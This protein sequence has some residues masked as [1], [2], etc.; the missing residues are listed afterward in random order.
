[1][2]LRKKSLSITISE[3][4]AEAHRLL[5]EGKPDEHMAYVGDAVAKYPRD[6]DLRHQYAISL[7]TLEPE[8]ART[9]VLRAVE[10][11]ESS[12]PSRL[13]RAAGVLLDLNDHAGALALVE[14]AAP[15]A[16]SPPVINKL[17][18]I[19]GVIAMHDRDYVVGER[20]L[21]AAHDNDP[22]DEFAARDLAWALV[23]MG[24]LDAALAIVDRTLATPAGG[25]PHDEQ[26]RDML[27]RFRERVE[28]A[29]RSAEG[30]S[31]AG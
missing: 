17:H 11:D 1:M 27:R 15:R 24:R 5:A 4:L 9:E 7:I 23:R 2:Q 28:Q 14:R 3:T 26:S 25:S 8:R 29:K 18:R 16:T 30:G 12:D 6:P 10:L 20:E 21:R 31:S 22:T 19:R 13:A